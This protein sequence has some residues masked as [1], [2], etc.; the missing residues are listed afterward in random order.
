MWHVYY[1][2][3]MRVAAPQLPCERMLTV[4]LPASGQEPVDFGG[5]MVATEPKLAASFRPKGHGAAGS[6]AA[7]DTSS[8]RRWR[9][10]RRSSTRAAGGGL[11]SAVV[12]RAHAHA[13]EPALTALS[14]ML[15]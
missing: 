4:L 1:V 8:A 14:P 7:A 15:L 12:L 3:T 13:G 11:G 10:A 2:R 9:L 5:L 6:G